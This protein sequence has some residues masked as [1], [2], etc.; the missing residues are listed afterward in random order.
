MDFIENTRVELLDLTNKKQYLDYENLFVK[1]FLEFEFDEKENNIKIVEIAEN[2]AEMTRKH[3]NR[4][5]ILLYAGSECIGFSFTQVCNFE[6]IDYL[7]NPNPE[8]EIGSE[9]WAFLR[10]FFIIPTFRKKGLGKFLHNSTI[11]KI[12]QYNVSEILLT[13][14]ATDFWIKL[15][16]QKINLKGFNDLEILKLYI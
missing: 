6:K 15:G 3:K 11:K 7:T 13:S 9:E 1:Y 8:M 10:E 4:W 5:I 16:Y 2:F 14:D 12:K